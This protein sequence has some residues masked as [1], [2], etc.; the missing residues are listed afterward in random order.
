M[1]N[2][3]GWQ[4]TSLIEYPD[5]ISTVLFTGGC[6]FRC[7][8]CYNSGL[9]LNPDKLQNISED[10]VIDYLDKRKYLYQAVVVSGGEPCMQEGLYDF[11]FK[12]KNLGLL[13]GL[14]TNGSFPDKIRYLL[15]SELLDYIAM[16]IKA[17]MNV[18]K[19]GTAAGI[20]CLKRMKRII[21]K[22]KQSIELIKNS[23][24]K[25]EFRTTFAPDIHN[26]EDTNAIADM[27]NGNYVVQAFLPGKTVMNGELNEKHSA[28]FNM[29]L[30]ESFLAAK[31]RYTNLSV[32]NI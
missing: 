7:P 28:S 25:Y 23:G 24:I 12:I 17:P 4:K 29:K 13:T 5:K 31:K 21:I 3:K 26:P 8:Y 2:F 19:Y 9:V 14:E 27:M 16:D 30:K 20:D 15:N 1:I 11:M 18:Y 32:R 22:I 6:N 10:Q